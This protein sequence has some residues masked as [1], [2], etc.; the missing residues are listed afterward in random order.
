MEFCIAGKAFQI[1]EDRMASKNTPG[2]A[3]IED[4]LLGDPAMIDADELLRQM[5]IA[6]AKRTR[7]YTDLALPSVGDLMAT[8]EGYTGANEGGTYSKL[9]EPFMLELDGFDQASYR[10]SWGAWITAIEADDLSAGEAASV[11]LT[12]YNCALQAALGI[13]E[14]TSSIDEQ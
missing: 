2:I 3:I 4:A 1:I 7:K 8:P 12:E 13:A 6:F 10:D 5:N 14:C 9:V 11:V